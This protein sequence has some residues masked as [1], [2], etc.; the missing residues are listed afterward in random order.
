VK[1]ANANS[2]ATLDD[3]MAIHIQ[4]A[5]EQSRGKISGPGGAAEMLGL[6]PGTLRARLRKL[7]I[8]FGRSAK[9]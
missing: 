2:I 1:N 9:K 6:K 3:A 4:K 5:L 7:K 8:P